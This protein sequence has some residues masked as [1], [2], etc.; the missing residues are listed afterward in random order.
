MGVARAWRA[1]G[2]RTEKAMAEL[3]QEYELMEEEFKTHGL[4]S[5]A[6]KDIKKY[7]TNVEGMGVASAG[8]AQKE[9]ELVTPK[10]YVDLTPSLSSR[11]SAWWSCPS[12]R[13]RSW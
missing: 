9:N 7:Y 13:P 2:A 12:N 11:R 1:G 6:V 3:R 4:N 5:Q 8:R 10:K